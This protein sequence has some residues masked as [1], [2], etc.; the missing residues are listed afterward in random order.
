[1]KL[2]F[3]RGHVNAGVIRI[4]RRI[5]IA[6]CGGFAKTLAENR[7]RAESRRQSIHLK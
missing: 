6:P 2:W 1:M 5:G 4:C 7:R 3:E